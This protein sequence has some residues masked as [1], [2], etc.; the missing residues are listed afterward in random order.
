MGSLTITTE[1]TYSHGKILAA[2]GQAKPI[3]FSSP[4]L[5]HI[6][7]KQNDVLGSIL[8]LSALLTFLKEVK[9]EY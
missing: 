2:F 9:Q 1:Y 5:K 7:I 8:R 4:T 3:L 6:E